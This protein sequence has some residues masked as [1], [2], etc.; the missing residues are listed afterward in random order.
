MVGNGVSRG[1]RGFESGLP[2]ELKERFDAA[3]A[4]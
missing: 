4:E 3:L 2:K 1:G